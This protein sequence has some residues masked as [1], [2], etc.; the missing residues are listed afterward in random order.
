MTQNNFV[1]E[2]MKHIIEGV[3][4]P[5]VQVE[6]AISPILSLFIE[7]ILN[8]YFRPN[9]DYSGSYKL[10]SPEFPLKK[11]NN[12]STN[13]D[14]LL[15]NNSKKI[16]IFFELKTDISSIDNEQM[17]RYF[18]YKNIIS[19]SSASILRENL[20][21]ITGASSK[22]SKYDY[23]VK[24]FDSV[25]QNPKDIKNIAIIYL[26]PDAIKN[27]INKKEEIDFTL[28]YQDLPISI[29]HK[30]ADYWTD[31]RKNLIKLD[32]F[33]DKIQSNDYSNNPLIVIVQ[34]IKN[35]LCKQSNQLVPVSIRLGIKGKGSRPNYQVKFNDGSIKTFYF[36]GEPHRVKKFKINKL[37]EEHLWADIK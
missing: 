36:S 30:Y 20:L 16:L 37:G 11:D 1:D 33:F 15:V 13:I 21:K 2:L 25:V 6:R 34:N 24:R 26:V 17:N 7:S 14:Y 22:S 18:D 8:E 29:T 3:N 5:K 12:Q 9:K 4:I 27:Q 10:V 28:N 19:E 32:E 31:V 35:Y 23:V